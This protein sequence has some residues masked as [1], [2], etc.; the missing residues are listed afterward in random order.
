MPA[1]DGIFNTKKYLYADKL[2]EALKFMH[3]NKMYDKLVIY[4]EAC[5]SGSMFEKILEDNLNI[6]AV[7]AANSH[8]S[9]WGTYCGSDAKVDGKSIGSCLGD[10]FSVNWMEDSDVA[11]MDM[12]T[13]QDQYETVKTKTNKSQVLQWGDL[14]WTTDPIGEFESNKN[15]NNVDLWKYFE[16]QGKQFIK[17]MIEYDADE[18]AKK[19]NG[20]VD[21]RDNMLHYLY[22]R[23]MAN[24]SIENQEALQA[25]IAHRMKVDKFFNDVF[26]HHMEAVHSGK[27]PLPTDFECYRYLVENY[28]RM[29]E[30]A[31]DYTLKYFKTFVAECEGLKSLPGAFHKTVIKM[32]EACK[33]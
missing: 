8:E 31:S 12:E 18:I 1:G 24:P 9:S 16:L 17:D 13:L 14:K 4:M 26:P 29:C 15:M 11:K 27:T 30:P 23:V 20:A 32:H 6:Y 28:E 3:T 5:E 10:L 19:N 33:Q 21:S 25:E 22:N 7:S 2:H